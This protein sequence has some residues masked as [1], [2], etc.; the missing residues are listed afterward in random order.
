[1]IVAS[2]EELFKALFKYLKDNKR[3]RK[4][5]CDWL[6]GKDMCAID[7]GGKNLPADFNSAESCDPYLLSRRTKK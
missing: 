1:M 5:F 6:K 2:F 4:F 7:D 3:I